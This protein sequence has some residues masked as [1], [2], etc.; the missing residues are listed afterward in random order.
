LTQPAVSDPTTD[1]RDRRHGANLFKSAESIGYK[2]DGGEGPLEFLLR[3]TYET[4]WDDHD[5]SIKGE[6]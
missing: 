1:E 4:G 2:N 3:I 5:R 6:R